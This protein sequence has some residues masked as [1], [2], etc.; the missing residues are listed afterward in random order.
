MKYLFPEG[1]E[2]FLGIFLSHA[3][4]LHCRQ[5]QVLLVAVDK[6]HVCVYIG[7]KEKAVGVTHTET[8]NVAWWVYIHIAVTGI[9]G[10][11]MGGANHFQRATVPLRGSV[12]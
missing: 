3:S 2:A 9:D 6:L 7:V 4:T 5:S 10:F 1:E 11:Q 12:I 8:K